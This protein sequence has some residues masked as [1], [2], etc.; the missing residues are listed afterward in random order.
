MPRPVDIITEAPHEIH[1]LCARGPHDCRRRH[2]RGFVGLERIRPN[3][4]WLLGTADTIDDHGVRDAKTL[5]EPLYDVEHPDA[6]AAALFLGDPRPEIS[7]TR[8]PGC[9]HYELQPGRVGKTGAVTCVTG[10]IAR[11]ALPHQYS[12]ENTAGAVIATVRTPCE[13]LILDQF[14]HED[15]YGRISPKLQ[16]FAPLDA[17]APYETGEIPASETVFYAGKASIQLRTPEIPRY[18]QMV[19]FVFDRMGWDIAKFDVYRVR[20]P[21]P[22]MPSY[23]RM[24]YDLP[25]PK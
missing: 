13:L 20:V 22:V 7:C 24:V 2:L 1:T 25:A 11:R 19:R 17:D 16:V 21:Y 12:A 10:E 3:Q 23:A 18:N 14:I 9:L 6:A 15:V 4:A 5:Y 8:S